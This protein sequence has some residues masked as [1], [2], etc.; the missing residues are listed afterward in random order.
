MSIGGYQLA[1]FLMYVV[2][3]YVTMVFYLILQVI[4]SVLDVEQGLPR[5]IG[6]I[7]LVDGVVLVLVSGLLW[8]NIRI[9]VVFLLLGIFVTLIVQKL[10]RV[11]SRW[12]PLS[13]GEKQDG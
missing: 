13:F 6:R 12:S 4:D 8:M 7:L 1:E 11:Y 2:C 10:S 5:N 3:V 9:G